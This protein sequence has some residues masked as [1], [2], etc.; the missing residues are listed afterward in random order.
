[1]DNPTRIQMCLPDR[2]YSP[3]ARIDIFTRLPEYVY[4]PDYPNGDVGPTT[5]MECF[6]R[7]PG[8]ICLPDYPNGAIRPATRMSFLPEYR[9]PQEPAK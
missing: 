8:H 2:I 3:I 4:V 9:P 6:A 1:M 7:L 5:R